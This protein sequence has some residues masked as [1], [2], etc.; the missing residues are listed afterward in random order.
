MPFPSRLAA[1]FASLFTITPAIA[2]AEQC[3][4][5]RPATVAVQTEV[6]ASGLDTPW[7]LAFLPDG[8]QLVTERPGRIRHIQNGVVSEPIRGVPRVVDEGQGG[9]LDIAV[10]PDFERNN[11]IYFTFSERGQGGA[12]TAVAR[13]KLELTRGRLRDVVTIFSASDKSGG[14]RHFGSRLRFATDGTIFVTLGDRGTQVRAQDTFDHAGSVIRI[15]RD[16]SVPADTPFADG[17]E[18]LPEIWSIGHRNPQGAAVHPETGALWTLSHG[19]AGGDEVNIPQ[20]GKNYGWP[21]ISYGSNYNGRPFQRGDTAPGFEQPTYYWDPSIAPSGFDFYM[22]EAPLIPGF[23]GSLFAG[24]LKGQHLS[25][26]ILRGDEVVAEERYF[27]G[28]F[29]RI[30]DVRTGPDGAL[31]LLTD[32][33]SGQVIRVTGASS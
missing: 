5:I 8:S 19:A 17:V 16:G 10:D 32:D 25:R 21:V 12:S 4:T 18:A 23:D 20:A 28:Q 24:A 27:E 26:L 7:G 6:I 33:R 11:L 22:P 13:A 29:G 14:G 2:I 9:L 31:W 3:C 15:N 30:R 1:A